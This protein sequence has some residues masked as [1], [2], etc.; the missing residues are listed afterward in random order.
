MVCLDWLLNTKKKRQEVNKVITAYIEYK[1]KKYFLGMGNT[2]RTV[3]A[4]AYANL[5][6]T[7]LADMEHKVKF[8]KKDIVNNTDHFSDILK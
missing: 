6:M 3:K 4:V 8:T 7:I 5:S 2:N 1:G